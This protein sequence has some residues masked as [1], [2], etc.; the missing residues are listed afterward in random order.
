MKPRFKNRR[1]AT[2]SAFNAEG[3]CD[4]NF[5][6]G[7]IPKPSRPG[8]WYFLDQRASR[9]MIECVPIRLSMHARN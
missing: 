5:G 2:I 9:R 7:E 3:I 1:T 4:N 6:Q 8:G